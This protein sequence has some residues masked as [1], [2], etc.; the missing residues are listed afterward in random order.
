VADPNTQIF[1]NSNTLQLGSSKKIIPLI[2]TFS[3]YERNVQIF[4]DEGAVEED[5]EISEDERTVTLVKQ[6]GN[7]I[8]PSS[9]LEL[10]FPSKHR[11]RKLLILDLKVWMKTREKAT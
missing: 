5:K 9:K 4:T 1:F 6:I 10:D 11:D 7:D 3:I 8:H 2:N